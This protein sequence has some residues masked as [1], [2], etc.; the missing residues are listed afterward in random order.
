MIILR[1]AEKGCDKIQHPSMIKI[2]N[3]LKREEKYLHM[4]KAKNKK[5]Y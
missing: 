1:D 2:L 4:I 5:L 3:K